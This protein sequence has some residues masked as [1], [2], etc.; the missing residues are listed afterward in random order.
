M[1]ARRKWRSPHTKPHGSIRST[2]TP[3]HTAVRIMVP[4]F[5]GM[6]GSKRAKRMAAMIAEAMGRRYAAASPHSALAWRIT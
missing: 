6:S 5:C 3:R 1:P 2:G 4:A